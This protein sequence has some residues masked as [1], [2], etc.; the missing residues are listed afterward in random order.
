MVGYNREA[1][2]T[3][4]CPIKLLVSYADL[5]RLGRPTLLK[6]TTVTFVNATLP[7]NY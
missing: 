1:K 4:F 7:T 2:P 5:M 6:Q 3:V